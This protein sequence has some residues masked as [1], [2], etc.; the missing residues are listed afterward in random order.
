MAELRELRTLEDA[1]A[2]LDEWVTSHRRLEL[3]FIRMEH[4]RDHWRFMYET[5]LDIERAEAALARHRKWA[6]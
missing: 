4:D 2:L 6:A 5:H 1:V 3:A